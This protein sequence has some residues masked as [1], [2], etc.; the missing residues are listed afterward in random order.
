VTSGSQV[1]LRPLRLP[2][3]LQPLR[4]CSPVDLHTTKRETHTSIDTTLSQWSGRS[5]EP[6]AHLDTA[7]VGCT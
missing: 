6:T 7:A 4:L 1:A 3:L 5:L 2:R